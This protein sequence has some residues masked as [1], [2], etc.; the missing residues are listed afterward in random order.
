M[1]FLAFSAFSKNGTKSSLYPKHSFSRKRKL[2]KACQW[3]VY[4]FL[5]QNSKVFRVLKN[6]S[7][8]DAVFHPKDLHQKDKKSFKNAP[9]VFRK[10]LGNLYSYFPVLFFSSF[11]VSWF[12]FQSPFENFFETEMLFQN[13][14]QLLNSSWDAFTKNSSRSGRK[15]RRDSNS[16]FKPK[17]LNLSSLLISTQPS[18]VTWT[19]LT[20]WSLDSGKAFQDRCCVA[21]K[22]QE[23]REGDS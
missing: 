9:S 4:T 18:L 1:Q 13:E 23:S 3:W 20:L 19:S 10:P 11:T 8:R 21:I 17:P 12:A 16:L 22:I 14:M 2:H 5:S 6:F 7:G 15:L